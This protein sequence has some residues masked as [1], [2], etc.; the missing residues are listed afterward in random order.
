MAY[1]VAGDN[2]EAIA[3]VDCLGENSDDCVAEYICYEEDK[4]KL[5]LFSTKKTLFLKFKDH[6][7]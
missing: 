7:F 2:E 3:I 6:K 1:C 5:G 4:S